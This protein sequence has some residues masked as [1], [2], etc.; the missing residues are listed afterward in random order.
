MFPVA[1]VLLDLKKVRPALA[2]AACVG[3]GPA[4]LATAGLDPAGF[5]IAMT[6]QAGGDH[7]R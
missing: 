3:G 5:D 1:P 7:D 2:G 4:G 6:Y